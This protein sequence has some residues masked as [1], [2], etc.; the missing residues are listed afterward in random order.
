VFYYY[1][2]SSLLTVPWLTLDVAKEKESYKL[3]F[4]KSLDDLI[5]EYSNPGPNDQN[6]TTAEDQLQPARLQSPF[7]HAGRSDQQ[8]TATV[9]D[10]ESSASLASH[11]N[12]APDTQHHETLSSSSG[13]LEDLHEDPKTQAM[14]LRLLET[15]RN[16]VASLETIQRPSPENQREHR[17]L[18]I[19]IQYLTARGVYD[20][21]ASIVGSKLTPPSNHRVPVHDHRA[22]LLQA[23]KARVLASCLLGATRKKVAA[24]E[25]NPHPSQKAQ[26]L[27]ENLKEDIQ[28]FGAVLE[29]WTTTA[30]RIEAQGKET[31]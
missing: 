17:I 2:Y 24:L 22:G 5:R 29:E 18:N 10:K 6:E 9:S 8:K 11:Q 20:T 21:S 7:E 19:D 26:E 4:N 30:E 25:T 31:G 16:K 23:L 1:A 13:H 27:C 28:Y 14:A 12:A 15:T 3:M